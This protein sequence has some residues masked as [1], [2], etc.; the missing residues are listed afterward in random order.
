MTKEAL[1][2]IRGLRRNNLLTTWEKFAEDLKERFGE[3]AFDDKLEEL[4]R[5]VQTSTMAEYMGRFEALLNEVEGQNEESLISYFIW[6][7]KLEIKNHLKI[8]RPTSLRR[9]LAVA[10]VHEGNKG[11]K[12]YKYGGSPYN[13]KSGP[14]I[15]T[16][17]VTGGMPIVRRTLTVEERKERTTKR[18]Y[19]NCDEQFSPGH[20]CK[21]KLFW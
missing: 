18:L 5:L 2:W 16:P 14:I 12:A 4:S 3:S 10:K 20:R 1:S 7:L 15:K 9:A 6:G 11:Y 17:L 13:P 19:F 21:G 8:N